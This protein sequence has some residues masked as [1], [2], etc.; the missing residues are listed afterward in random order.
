MH[1]PS[2]SQHWFIRRSV[3]TDSFVGSVSFGYECVR[4]CVLQGA[5]FCNVQ[6]L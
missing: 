1:D 2:A 3:I 6:G 5:L 4:A